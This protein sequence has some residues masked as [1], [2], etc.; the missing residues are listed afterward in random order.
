MKKPSLLIIFLSVFIDLVGFGIVMP[1]LPSY[2]KQFGAPGWMI[3]VIIASYSVAQ[4]IFAPWW[5]RLSDRI[6]RRPVLLI[7]NAGAACSYALFSQACGMTGNAGLTL[8]VVSRVFAGICGAN[9]SVAS[10]YIADISEPEKRTQRM[11]L[12]GMAF[13]FGFIIGPAL[14]GQS[15]NWFG[16]KGPG[17]VAA[18][19][20]AFNF[21]FGL[22]ALKES[23]NSANSAPAPRRTRLESIRHLF[24]QPVVKTVVVSYFFATLCFTCFESTFTLLALEVYGLK[25]ENAHYL[26][27][28]CGILGAVLQGGVVGRLNRAMGE[29]KLIVA[30][31]VVV[32]VSLA[33]MPIASGWGAILGVL[34]LFAIG[35]GANRPPTFGLISLNSSAD[36]Q[37]AALGVA[38]SAGSLARIVGPVMANVLYA[39]HPGSIYYLCGAIAL[40]TAAACWV[41][42]VKRAPAA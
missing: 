13:G 6:G 17:M 38:Q 24:S 9:L 29:R 34:A 19:I 41:A 10:A 3:G 8:F 20:C 18:S 7:S 35:S 22:A 33:L 40:A 11:G 25:Q 42:L 36:E 2:S 28:Y 31:M 39:I 27:A 14:G 12:I 1:M 16:P 26:F 15:Y 21:L 30:S 32:A 37:G 5:G 4:F 23:R